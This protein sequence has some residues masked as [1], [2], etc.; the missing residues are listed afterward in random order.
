MNQHNWPVLF[1][2]AI[3]Q[4]WRLLINLLTTLEG[5]SLSGYPVRRMVNVNV[6]NSGPTLQFRFVLSLRDAGSFYAPIFGLSRSQTLSALFVLLLIQ[7][8]IE[9]SHTA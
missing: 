2:A 8:S 9:C 5:R 7:P 6:D 4:Q 3:S 1:V